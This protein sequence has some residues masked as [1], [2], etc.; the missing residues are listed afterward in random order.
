MKKDVLLPIAAVVIAPIGA[1]AADAGSLTDS[2]FKLAKDKTTTVDI[3]AGSYTFTFSNAEVSY[4]VDGKATTVTSD[5][6]FTLAKAGTITVK[7]TADNPTITIAITGDSKKAKDAKVAELTAAFT[8][9]GSKANSHVTDLQDDA[10]TNYQVEISAAIKAIDD[11][12]SYNTWATLDTKSATITNQIKAYDSKLTE[13]IAGINSD[14]AGKVTAKQTELTGKITELTNK[15]AAETYAAAQIAADVKAL[16]KQVDDWAANSAKYDD[17]VQAYIDQDATSLTAIEKTVTGG[18]ASIT[19]KA[20]TAV[21]AN[22]AAYDAVA[23]KIEEAKDLYSD[24]TGKVSAMKGKINNETDVYKKFRTAAVAALSPELNKI[25]EIDN[26]EK[27]AK[28]TEEDNLAALGDI[29]TNLESIYN[30]YETR[31]NTLED[32]YTIA[33]NKINEKQVTETTKDEQGVETTTTTGENGFQAQFDA[34]TKDILADKDEVASYKDVIDGVNKLI[35]DLQAKF[36]EARSTAAEKAAET[37]PAYL[38]D[39]AE[40]ITKIK[41]EIADFARVE[42][43]IYDSYIKATGEVVDNQTFANS[44]KKTLEDYK[45]NAHYAS[46]KTDIDNLVTELREL[47]ATQY[48][49]AKKQIG[50]EVTDVVLVDA[51]KTE[52]A[53]EVGK[54]TQLKNNVA[55]YKDEY[56]KNSKN[57]YDAIEKAASDGA[58]QEK[59]L[60]FANTSVTNETSEYAKDKAKTYAD[61]QN[62]FVEEYK[63]YTTQLAALE[64]AKDET[65]ASH[66]TALEAL[67]AKAQTYSDG[68]AARVTA[69]NEAY[70]ADAATYEA[71]NLVSTAV[72][73][74]ETALNKIDLYQEQLDALK[75]GADDAAATYG[76]A[77]STLK[78][79]SATIQSILD[80]QTAET[81]NIATKGTDGKL[82]PDED[83]IAA[84]ATTSI[85]IADAVIN[86]LEVNGDPVKDDKGNVTGYTY[87]SAKTLLENLNTAATAAKAVV[88]AN[89][90]V[91]DGIISRIEA[92][93]TTITKSLAADKNTGSIDANV[94]KLAYAED[95]EVAVAGD[96]TYLSSTRQSIITALTSIKASTETAKT[97]EKLS[98]TDN[99]YDIVTKVNDKKETVTDEEKSADKIDYLLKAQEAN[100]AA[101][102]DSIGKINDSDKKYR[103]FLD[104]Y[105]NNVESKPDDKGKKTGSLIDAEAELAKLTKNKVVDGKNSDY[106]ANLKAEA[107]ALWATNKAKVDAAHATH[108]VDLPGFDVTQDAALEYVNNYDATL[109]KVVANAVANE[110]NYLALV[111]SIDEANQKWTEVDKL[112]AE[113]LS[114]LKEDKKA[115]LDDVQLALVDANVAIKDAY[116]KGIL[117]DTKYDAEKSEVKTQKDKIDAV[118]KY[119]L[120]G[121]DSEYALQ[122]IADNQ[123]KY[124]EFYKEIKDARDVYNTAYSTLDKYLT[125]YPEY[126]DNDEALLGGYQETIYAQSDTISNLVEQALKDRTERNNKLEQFD[127]SSYITAAENI[128]STINTNL[129]AYRN[130]A[131]T[132]SK[133]DFTGLLTDYK[134]QRDAEVSALSGYDAN[135]VGKYFSTYTVVKGE[136]AK[137]ENSAIQEIFNAADEALEDPNFALN[138]AEYKAAL[139][140]FADAVDLAGEFTKAKNGFADKQWGI[141]DDAAEKALTECKTALD[142]LAENDA[143]KANYTV[144]YNSYVSDNADNSLLDRTY[145]NL[146]DG[147]NVTNLTASVKALTDEINAAAKNEADSDKAYEF[148]S[149]HVT[150]FQEVLDKVKAYSAEYSLASLDNQTIEKL[151]GVDKL[152]STLVEAIDGYK[153]SYTLH[154][155]TAEINRRVREI[156]NVLQ[157]APTTYDTATDSYGIVASDKSGTDG[158]G[159]KQLITR[160]YE[161]TSLDNVIKEFEAN[162]KLSDD[163]KTEVKDLRTAFDELRNTT[164]GATVEKYDEEVAALEAKR[165]ETYI[166]YEKQLG[167]LQQAL[168][169]GDYAAT[170]QA[171]SD[172][173]KAVQDVIDGVDYTYASVENLPL[174]ADKQNAIDAQVAKT[175]ST[176]DAISG[177]LAELEAAVQTATTNHAILLVADNVK[178]LTEANGNAVEAAIA[179]LTA[180]KKPYADNKDAYEKYTAI[181]KAINDKNDGLQETVQD[182]TLTYNLERYGEALELQQTV[183]DAL[184][185]AVTATS[186]SY[187]GTL[188][189]IYTSMYKVEA[190]DKVNNLRSEIAEAQ[191]K[192]DN[193]QGTSENNKQLYSSDTN[194]KIKETLKSAQT[195]L[196]NVNTYVDGDDLSRV[197][198]YSLFDN[199][200]EESAANASSA[201]S[202]YANL[203]YDIDGNKLEEP[204]KVTL[205]EAIA[206]VD[207]KLAEVNELVEAA[208]EL[209]KDNILGDIDHDGN[210][211]VN[212]F[213]TLRLIILE[214]SE[215]PA[216]G[217][218]DFVRADAN[219]DGNIN[220]A[221]LQKVALLSKG[222]ASSAL[223]RVS[224]RRGESNDNVALSV[225]GEGINRRLVISLNNAVEYVGAQF[226]LVL[227]A[228]LTVEGAEGSARVAGLDVATSLLANGTLRVLVSSPESVAI[229]GNEGAIVFVDLTVSPEYNGAA[230]S[231]ENVVATDAKAKAYDLTTVGEATG[232]STVTTTE[233]IKGKVYNVG[234]QLLNGLKKGVNIIRGNDGSTK[235]VI[236]K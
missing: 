180:D 88:A 157:G 150:R 167:E 48:A 123:K 11:S 189:N 36:D 111:A 219:S 217:T 102:V 21:A 168:T 162:T 22:K 84:N 172:A 142:G 132:E 87:T 100:A 151:E 10:V 141:W 171:L 110:T 18:I 114:S 228:G 148:Y 43:A 176:L 73:H 49:E 177:K 120:I 207:A 109:K 137:Q 164:I 35:T 223:N 68:I 31:Y 194:E 5:T 66:Y 33:Y 38:T 199:L 188:Q 139:E 129:D 125:L 236:V 197:V 204:A 95:A 122:L 128:V 213:A 225:S 214:K 27:N 182:E 169:E 75:L 179:E 154:N 175:Q 127:P 29:I 170:Q 153:E 90:K 89:Q 163:Q 216:K 184:Y 94:L 56:A 117:L 64:F 58:T 178:A 220:V 124:D 54:L 9:V 112:V 93:T 208:Q 71:K 165:H 39:N 99:D 192:V 44:A 133:N 26:P 229:Q 108:V 45:F 70:T 173:I 46:A 13:L 2:N 212:D 32:A 20:E 3:V 41:D 24:L 138:Y 52:K 181:V 201:P 106:Y 16:Q 47:I 74:V 202:A 59:S 78:S 187:D 152:I 161:A 210:V 82:S 218:A 158:V 69:L 81:Q 149:A 8:E 50:K 7:A 83:Y 115:T 134:N 57:Y 193:E 190:S 233:Y 155:Q 226:D 80:T 61:V 104:L 63:A 53:G 166:G 160:D 92:I 37:A 191:A 231:I 107:D 224:A 91:Y 131:N 85:D 235:K 25:N 126:V 42:K 65:P 72:S 40:A 113:D 174:N 198:W 135:L 28:P 136:A 101:L 195:V 156:D 62:Q 230:V 97:N 205:A 144:S 119:Y 209:Q 103:A 79:D 1:Y 19:T 23:A 118:E 96:A 77:L 55:T 211:T 143:A 183:L 206:N 12:D 234:G 4:T 145:E 232:I 147:T 17:G 60:A 121:A 186:Y 130:L 105:I 222:A 221:D 34:L 200:D 196:D 140:E 76:S 116:S 67:A 146:S 98:G 227:P 30:D 86:K 51:D 159:L 185:K 15:Y 6:V 14:A 215:T 203:N